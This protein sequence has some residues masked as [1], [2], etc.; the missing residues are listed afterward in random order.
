MP[1]DELVFFADMLAAIEKVQRY[2]E[3]ITL[4]EFLKTRCGS[5]QLSATLR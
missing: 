1:R 5:M 2:L 3:N 4:E